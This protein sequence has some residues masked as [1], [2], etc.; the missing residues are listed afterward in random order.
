MS[1]KMRA[2]VHLLGGDRSPLDAIIGVEQLPEE[3]G[4]ASS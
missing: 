2:R 3:M 1:A 4:G